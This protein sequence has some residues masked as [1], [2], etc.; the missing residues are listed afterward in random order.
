MMIKLSVL[1]SLIREALVEAPALK[2]VDP[3][4]DPSKAYDYEMKNGA[5]NY[6]TERGT[7]VIGL[8]YRSPGQAPGSSGDPF[9]PEDAMSYVGF[10]PPAD[11]NAS[12][13]APPGA[14]GEQGEQAMGD[15][16]DIDD[17]AELPDGL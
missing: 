14:K 8:W 11:A 4:L 3:L 7:D 13:G 1:R 16:V 6:D 2:P 17:P 10:R 12:A 5:Y 9:R 15:T